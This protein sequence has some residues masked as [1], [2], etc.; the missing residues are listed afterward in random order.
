MLTDTKKY[1]LGIVLNAII[2]L[3]A[4]GFIMPNASKNSTSATDRRRAIAWVAGI[5]IFI[6]GLTAWLFFQRPGST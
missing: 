1:R 4:V 3:I 5:G 6:N 2:L